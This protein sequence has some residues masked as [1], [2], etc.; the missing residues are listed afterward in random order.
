MGESVFSQMT[1]LAQAHGAINLG[2]GFP[3]EDGPD[4]L[5]NAAL[6]AVLQGPNQYAAG[7]GDVSLRKAVVAKMERDYGL[8]YCPLDEVTICNGA[9]EALAACFLGLLNPGDEVLLL[10][11]VFDCYIPAVTLAGGVPRLLTCVAPDFAIDLAALEA[12]ITPRTRA[13][14]LNS[15]WNPCGKVLSSA[16]LEAIAAMLAR[17]PSIVAITDEVYEH[18]VFAPHRHHPLATFPG[19]RERTL[20]ISSFSKTL[21]VTGWKL[22][23][24]LGPPPLTQAVRAAH[25]FLTFCAASPLQ[26]GCARV[27]DKLGSYYFGFAEDYRRR[28][29]F[30]LEALR[31][32]GFRPL[33]P[34]GTYFILT[35]VRE[36]GF[37]DDMDF[38][39]RLPAFLG[40]AAFPASTLYR[41]HEGQGLVRW[42]FCKSAA[43]LRE[44]GSRLTRL[45][46]LP[47]AV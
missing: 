5:K 38:C 32:V 18:I 4:W 37:R 9:T 23:Y 19:M 20:V 17:H 15:P 1:R 28:C 2:Q 31:R 16:E 27:L 26:A 43:T 42:A 33:V 21:S 45:P 3:E 14:L 41:G 30:F 13:F 34:Q 46:E 11:P 47:R 29:D 24:A 12:M 10:E 40:V 7:P 44:A 6:E 25:Q 22:G 35:D 36:L 39:L 8:S